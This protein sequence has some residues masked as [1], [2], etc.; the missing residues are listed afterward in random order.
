MFLS[1]IHIE[2]SEALD[3]ATRKLDLWKSFNPTDSNL[4]IKAARPLL[5]VRSFLSILYRI[6]LFEFK[7]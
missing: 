3:E 4:N 1:Q 5:Q 7:F 6:D 2:M